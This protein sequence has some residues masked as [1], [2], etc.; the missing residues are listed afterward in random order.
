[1]QMMTHFQMIAVLK[2]VWAAVGKKQ[3]FKQ[4]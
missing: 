2:Y 1:M 4:A 3:R